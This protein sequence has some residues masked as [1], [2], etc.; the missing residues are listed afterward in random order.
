MRPII[1]YDDITT[2]QP[3]LP[4]PPPNPKH[5]ANS[6]NPQPPAKK[7]KTGP[8]QR[9]RGAANGRVGQPVQHWDDPGNQGMQMSYDDAPRQ[10]EVRGEEEEEWDE[11]EE[12]RELSHDEIWDDSALIDA[13]NSAAAEYEAFHGPG[14]SWKQEPVKKSPLWYNVPPEKTSK[15]KLKAAP[16]KTNGIAVEAEM[17]GR[18][19]AADSSP[20]NFDTFV[21]T[22]DPSLA[23]AGPSLSVPAINA[24]TLGSGAEAAIVSQ[25][26]AFSNAMTAMYWSGYWTAVYHCRRNESAPQNGAAEEYAADQIEDGLE[27]GEEDDD[28]D[29]L[30]AQR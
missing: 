16:S 18:T 12:S 3:A 2:P 4:P 30:P 19:E 28:E 1:S 20:L 5:Q 9:Q 13:W 25:D 29:M 24:A 17:N 21:P 26:E 22:H 8:N 27:E 6:S 15:G 23:P 11:E 10:T 7:R 14:K